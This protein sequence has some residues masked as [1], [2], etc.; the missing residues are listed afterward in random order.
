MPDSVKGNVEQ[1]G[2][3]DAALPYTWLY[4]IPL[5]RRKFQRPFKGLSQVFDTNV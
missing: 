5:D 1:G 3:E 2:G 4:W